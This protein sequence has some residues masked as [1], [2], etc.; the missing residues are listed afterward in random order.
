[1]ERTD[2]KP[3]SRLPVTAEVGDEGGSYAEPSLQVETFSGPAGNA[4]IDPKAAASTNGAELAPIARDANDS[5][6]LVKHATD[7][8]DES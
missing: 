2:E 6:D 4:R 5:D 1:M 7:A 8:P 3:E